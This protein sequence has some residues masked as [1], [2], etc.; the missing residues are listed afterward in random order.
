MLTAATLGGARFLGRESELGT[1]AVG[2]RADLYL[3]DGDPT[4]DISSIRKGRLVVKDGV[5][6]FPDEIHKVLEVTPFATHV[7]LRSAGPSTPAAR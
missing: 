5:F 2:K 1:I 7:E 3:V 6:Y 4:V